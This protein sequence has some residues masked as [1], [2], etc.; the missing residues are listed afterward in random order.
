MLGDSA[1]EQWIQDLADVDEFT[2]EQRKS[3]FFVSWWCYDCLHDARMSAAAFLNERANL[4]ENEVRHLL[5]RAAGVY[6]EEAGILLQAFHGKETF[7]G[8]WSGKTIDQWTPEVRKNEIS[9]LESVRQ[10]ETRAL[11]LLDEAA[12]AWIR[13]RQERE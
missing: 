4:F 12:S 1:F 9:V 6:T 3:L 13:G 5:L 11:S 2:Q 8:P 10:Q 7:L